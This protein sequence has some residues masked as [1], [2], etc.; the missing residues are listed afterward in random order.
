MI[1]KFKNGLQKEIADL[2]SAN[3]GRADLRYGQK[4]SCLKWSSDA[5]ILEWR[6]VYLWRNN[7]DSGLFSG[8][9]VVRRNM[10]LDKEAII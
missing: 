4:R 9:P 2:R 6:A 10:A 7:Y 5:I 8:V 3:L 1:I